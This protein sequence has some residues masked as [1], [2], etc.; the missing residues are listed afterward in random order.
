MEG[1]DSLSMTRISLAWRWSVKKT[2]KKGMN[3]NNAEEQNTTSVTRTRRRQGVAGRNSLD[4]LKIKFG[5][6]P[7]KKSNG[8]EES[9]KRE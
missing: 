5:D 6:G 1:R 2:M 4:L 9:Y 3:K 7:V 8:N